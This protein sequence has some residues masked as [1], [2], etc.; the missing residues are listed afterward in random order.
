MGKAGWWLRHRWLGLPPRH[1]RP[2]CR[3][4]K[5][6]IAAAGCWLVGLLP[7]CWLLAGWLLPSLSCV[8]GVLIGGC[9]GQPYVQGWGVGFCRFLI[10][11]ILLAA[12]CWGFAR[13]LLSPMWGFCYPIN[14]PTLGKYLLSLF[15]LFWVL[16]CFLFWH[17]I[18][19][20]SHVPMIKR[21]Y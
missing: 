18:C 1:P 14:F 2:S 10:V 3:R 11:G 12:G 8:C 15:F 4:F 16:C 19:L 7:S 6:S 9:A 5:Q 20:L 21:V 17:G 13:W